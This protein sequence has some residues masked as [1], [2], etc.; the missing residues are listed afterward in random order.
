[1]GIACNL[2]E[3]TILRERTEA[4]FGKRVKVHSDFEA[5]RD[6]VFR[7]TKSHVSET[8]LERLWGYSTRGY[9][10]VSRRTLDVLCLYIGHQNWDIFLETLKKEGAQESDMFDREAVATP[11]LQPGTRLR[12]G[13]PPDRVCVIRYLGDNRFIAEETQNAKLQAGDTFSCLQFQLHRP[14][15]GDNLRDSDGNLKGTSY[16][17]GLIHGLTLLQILD[18]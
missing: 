3:I 17:M 18:N 5:L 14:L 11:D 2:P 6:D 16:G 4:T 13:W 1:M 15:Y 12:V 7:K 9:D 8:T 10:S